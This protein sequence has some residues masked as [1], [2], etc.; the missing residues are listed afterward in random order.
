MKNN[1]GVIVRDRNF[2][3]LMIFMG[4]FIYFTFTTSD[5]FSYYNIVNLT[6]YGVEIGL[7]ALAETLIIISGKGGIDL[8]IGSI[9][10]LSAMTIGVLSGNIG[11]N[12]W[13]A[14]IIGVGVATLAGLF[15]GIAVSLIRIPPLLVTLSTMYIYDSLALL[16]SMD[17]YGNAMP[18]SNFPESYFFIG[19]YEILNIPIQIFIIFI[20]IVIILHLLLSKTIYGKH[21]YAIG[22]N[23]KVARFSGLPNNKVRILAYTIGGFLAGIAALTM[24]SRI[25]SARPDLGANLNLRA[26]TIAVLGGTSITG[27]QGTII[28]TVI[29]IVLITFLNNGLQLSGVNPIWQDGILGIILIAS[30]IINFIVY[31]TN[32]SRS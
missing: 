26:I 10:S 6:K 17:K 3:L 7:L 14:A 31:R 4:I 9:L 19:Q 5:F 32:S 18:V 25:G 22:L 20:P 28:G 23:D 29:A 30:A 16:I 11:L 2:I 8:S 1:I 27:G 21:L 24:T 13:I 12:I 15:N